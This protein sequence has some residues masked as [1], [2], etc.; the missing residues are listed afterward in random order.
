MLIPILG[1]AYATPTTIASC[2]L[3]VGDIRGRQ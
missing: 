1:V 3:P 2:P